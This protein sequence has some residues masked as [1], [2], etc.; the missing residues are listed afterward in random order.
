MEVNRHIKGRRPLP[1]DVKIRMIE[2]LPET[3]TIDI[4]ATKAVVLHGP[5]QFIRS[6][7][8]ILKRQGGPACKASGMLINQRLQKII[9]QLGVINRRLGI[10]LS[11]DAWRVKREDLHFQ[12]TLIH[13]WDSLLQEITEQI[14]H[15]LP[16]G[17]RLGR[18]RA[19]AVTHELWD[20]E[21]LFERNGLHIF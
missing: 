20:D 10:G 1:D 8:G 13:G 16:S 3:M 4:G 2:I 11:L 5:F 7:P 9:H 14:H 15:V 12:A 6:R 18:P 17:G 21:V 19:C